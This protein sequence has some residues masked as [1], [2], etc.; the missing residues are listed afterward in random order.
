M[1]KEGTE[2]EN[3]WSVQRGICTQTTQPEMGTGTSC[4]E[5]GLG[6]EELGGQ[7]GGRCWR[8]PVSRAG[9]GIRE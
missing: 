5:T 1:C 4:M 9:N 3:C 6:N 7:D 8:D 2:E